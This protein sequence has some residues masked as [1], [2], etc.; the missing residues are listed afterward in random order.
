MI[1]DEKP[2]DGVAFDRAFD[3]LSVQDRELLVLHHLDQLP[4]D[5]IAD[6]LQVPVGTIKARLHRARNALRRSLGREAW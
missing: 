5:E 6:R 4:L 3:R 2:P 1:P